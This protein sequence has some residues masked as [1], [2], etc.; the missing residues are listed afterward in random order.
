MT[1]IWLFIKKTWLFLWQTCSLNGS[2][3]WQFSF[4]FRFFGFSKKKRSFK[5][6]FLEFWGNY[7]TWLKSHVFGNVCM[8]QDVF[9]V[10]TQ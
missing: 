1:K 9:L 2:I 6:I 3:S 5:I 8:A 7:V 4:E 10:A